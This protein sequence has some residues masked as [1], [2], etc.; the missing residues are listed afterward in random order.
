VPPVLAAHLVLDV[1]ATASSSKGS[2]GS[3]TFLILIAI[4][5][6]VYLVFLRPRQQRQRQARE[7]GRKADVGDRIVTIGGMVGTIVSEDG[8]QFTMSTGN[9][10]ELTFIKEAILRKAPVEEPVADDDD[11]QF[12][13][14]PP[15]FDGAPSD[16]AEHAD[17]AAPG[18]DAGTA[19]GEGTQGSGAT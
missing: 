7:Q 6:V 13:G 18:T 5:A 16:T 19:T 12:S 17:G 4:F 14:P 15:A 3:Y 11:A 8:K 1:A 10:T 9:G 2:S